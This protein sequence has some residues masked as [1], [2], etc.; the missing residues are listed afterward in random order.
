MKLESTGAPATI[1]T[2]HQERTWSRRAQEWDHSSMPGLEDVATAVIQRAGPI[3]GCDVVD[4]GCGSGQLTLRLASQARS[5]LAVDFS[6]DMLNLLRA[7]AA[8]VGISNIETTRSSL[9]ALDLPARSVDVIVTNYA[10]HHL[11]HRE[12][13]ALL[14]RAARWLRPGGR[15][16][17]GD[18]MFGL[19]G[20][21]ESRRII[22]K[23]VSSIARRGPAGLWRV[24]KNGWRILVARQECPAPMGMWRQ[25]M[26]DAGLG[27]IR[28]ERIVAEAAVV[29]GRLPREQ[30]GASSP[31]L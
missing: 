7:R 12:K 9:Q 18:M 30:A 1:R 27:S 3:D 25:M 22:A 10:L 20:D 11:R 23:K 14:F 5:V 4:L 19:A 2:L 21:A 31:A 24:A 13:A 6:A 29:S 16:V 28:C 8:D 26:V 15:I 17:I